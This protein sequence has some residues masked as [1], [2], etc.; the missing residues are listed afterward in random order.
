M[1]DFIQTTNM[2]LTVP[3]TGVTLGPDWANE[4]NASLVLIDAHDH[5]QGNGVQINPAGLNISTDLPFNG[6]NAT[7][8]RTTRFL[9]TG[10]QPAGAADLTC[11][12][13]FGADL[14]YRD[15]NGNQ[16][17]ITQSGGVTGATGNITNLT[18]PASVTYVA[19]TSTFVFQSAASTPAL[20]DGASIILRNLAANSNGLT[21]SPPTLTGDYTITLPPLPVT[22]SVVS[23]A[24]SGAMATLSIDSTLSIAGNVLAVANGGITPAQV[25]SGFGLLPTGAVVPFGGASAPTGYLLCDG[26]SY[27]RAT[28]PDLFS[29]IGTAYGTADGT[30]FNVPDMRGY[31]M[32]GVT[33]GSAKDPNASTRT[34]AATGGNIGNNVGSVQADQVGPLTLSMS[35][36]AVGAGTTGN[37]QNVVQSDA[38]GLSMTTNSNGTSETRPVNLYFNFLV[39]T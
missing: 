28:Y 31:F 30:H 3:I 12:Y 7:L 29:A 24:T 32:R 10:V 9:P 15:G 6:N 34:A 39:K 16:V 5:S 2:G 19:G 13:A 26:A 22:T 14:Y 17:R 21:L 27:L 33:G 1:A 38:V 25:I 20:L 8:L 37:P 35:G 4:V 11:L 23:I 18:S 36:G